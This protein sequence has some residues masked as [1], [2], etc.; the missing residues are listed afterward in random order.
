MRAILVILTVVVVM[1]LVNGAMPR[2]AT[3]A[4]A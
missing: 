3:P 1:V 2:P 4:P